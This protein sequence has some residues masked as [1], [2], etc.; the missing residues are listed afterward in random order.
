MNL[1]KA[2]LFDYDGVLTTD[3]SGSVTLCRYLSEKT[4]LPYERIRHA[5]RQHNSEPEI[6][7]TTYAEIWPE[8][9]R[10]LGCDM[11]SDLLLGAFESTPM[12]AAMFQFARE[13]KASHSVG[14]VTDNKKDR[15]DHLKQYQRL[16]AVFAPIV[17]SAEVG[18]TKTHPAI[19]QFAL[20]SLGVRPEECIFIDNSR[21]NLIAPAAL[22]VKTIYFD[23]EEN[24]VNGLIRCLSERFGVSTRGAI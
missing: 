21:A 3:K 2:V 10:A 6:G 16:E 5:F 7:P 8:V 15:I 23:D 4:T 24:D 14:I 12:N 1:I 22:G 20:D 11:S 13:L 17:V 9:C 18:C 19:F